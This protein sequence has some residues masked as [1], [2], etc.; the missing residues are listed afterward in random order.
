MGGALTPLKDHII[1]KMALDATYIRVMT[2][3]LTGLL[4]FFLIAGIMSDTDKQKVLLAQI[5]L[6]HYL[7]H[8]EL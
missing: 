2:Y 6:K 7:Q 1:A 5:F 8:M 3:V 4:C